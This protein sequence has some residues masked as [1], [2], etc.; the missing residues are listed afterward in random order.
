[1]PTHGTQL[2]RFQRRLLPYLR[3]AGSGELADEIER[4]LAEEQA[5]K[6]VSRDLEALAATVSAEVEQRNAK[7]L[8]AA[9]AILRAAKQLAQADPNSKAA[10]AARQLQRAL[11]AQQKRPRGRRGKVRS[12]PDAV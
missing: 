1:M 4:A 10:E 3:A 8:A 9:L 12:A 7:A 5:M 11:R 2:K 6:A